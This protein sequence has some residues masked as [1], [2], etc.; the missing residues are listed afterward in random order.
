MRKYSLAMFHLARG[1]AKWIFF[2][3][4][5]F[6]LIRKNVERFCKQHFFFKKH[7][8]FHCALKPSGKEMKEKVKCNINGS[9]T[10]NGL[11]WPNPSCLKASQKN[12]APWTT[13]IFLGWNEE[14]PGFYFITKELSNVDA[15]KGSAVYWFFDN[16]K[17]NYN[18]A[19]GQTRQITEKV[20]NSLIA[21]GWTEMSCVRRE[22]ERKDNTITKRHGPLP[23]SP[24]ILPSKTYPF[25]INDHR[26]GI[27]FQFGT[28]KDLHAL[29]IYHSKE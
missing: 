18:D 10:L 23:A 27:A 17:W 15:S 16:P 26:L 20:Q 6:H 14:L 25:F 1:N 24:L 13:L 7:F 2:I 4:N 9:L 29:S 28:S 11:I 21:V 22:G 8:L 3:W 12:L 19:D 5:P